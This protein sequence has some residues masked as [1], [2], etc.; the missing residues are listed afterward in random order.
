MLFQGLLDCLLVG[1]TKDIRDL[2][3]YQRNEFTAG[4]CVQG[5]GRLVKANE[6]HI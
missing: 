2:T 3:G 1:I 6:K 5:H 4:R